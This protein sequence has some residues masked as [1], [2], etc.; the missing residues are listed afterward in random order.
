MFISFI[1][2]CVCVC[3]CF[4][5]GGGEEGGG[6]YQGLGFLGLHGQKADIL[7]R[8]KRYKGA[9]KQTPPNI[10]KQFLGYKSH[11]LRL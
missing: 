4:L 10:A 2:W 5:G 8:Y 6:C 7:I 9:C 11:T 1:V 3:D